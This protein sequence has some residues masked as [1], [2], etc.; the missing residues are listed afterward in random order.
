[1][2]SKFKSLAD[3]FKDAL[4]EVFHVAGGEVVS[5]EYKETPPE[6]WLEGFDAN[7]KGPIFDVKV[8]FPQE[9]TAQRFFYVEQDIEAHCADKSDSN[10]LIDA[11]LKD[12]NTDFAFLE[13]T[14]QLGDALLKSQGPFPLS[15]IWQNKLYFTSGIVSK[16]Y[17]ECDLN[18]VW[19]TETL[20]FNIERFN[21]EFQIAKQKMPEMEEKEVKQNNTR[22]F[23]LER[24]MAAPKQMC[25]AVVPRD[26]QPKLMISKRRLFPGEVVK[27]ATEIEA[28]ASTIPPSLLLSG[29]PEKTVSEKPASPVAVVGDL[30]ADSKLLTDKRR[31]AT[32]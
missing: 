6:E 32:P 14:K 30:A 11:F 27:P 9:N 18:L 16:T 8:R 5:F 12:L 25:Q 17:H 19:N 31:P 24:G 7:L 2:M 20:Q 15:R 21:Q 13:L 10:Q 29:G 3:P 4:K 1:M 26:F 28:A 22:G 23:S